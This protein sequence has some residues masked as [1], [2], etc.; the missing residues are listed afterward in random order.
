[1]SESNDQRFIRLALKEDLGRGDITTKAVGVKGETSKGEVIAKEN[2]VISGI[3]PFR[4][5]FKILSPSF[6]FKILIKDGQR[7][8]PGD[9][10]IELKGPSDLM[11]IG[12]RTSMNILCHL[13]GVATTTRQYV[14]VIKGCRAK[15]LD[16]RKTMPGMRTWEKDAVKHGGG[17]NHRLGLY[18]MYLVKENHIASAGGI[19]NASKAVIKHKKKTGAKFEVE[20]RNIDELR[21]AMT[22]KPDFIL[23]D[24]FTV[25]LLRKAVALAKIINRKVTLEASGNVSLRNVAKIAATG[26][27]RISIGRITH[28]APSLDLSFTVRF[29]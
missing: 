22:F 16:T 14:D 5:V 13:S 12:E 19:E 21:E 18:D 7:V 24:N 29:K 4:Q 28:S 1:M 26:V 15:I 17:E 25:P 9:R 8:K 2:G 11:L 20:V 23:L 27:D 10:V 6:R 3:D